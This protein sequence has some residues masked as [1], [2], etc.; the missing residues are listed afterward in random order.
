MATVEAFYHLHVKN[1]G[2]RHGRSVVA[3]A[4]YRAGETLW[5]EAEERESV[6]GGRRDVVHAEI[7]LP[8]GAPHWMAV[9]ATLW[10]AVEA[11]EKRHDARLAKEIEFSLPREL[12]REAWIN[13]AREMADAYTS[14]GFVVDLAVH[15]DGRGHNPHVHLLLATRRVTATGFSGKLRRA[16]S[17]AFITEA[18]QRWQQVANTALGKAGANAQ[19][20]ARSYK[21]RGMD[22]TPTRHHGPDPAARAYGRHLAAVIGGL[23]MLRSGDGAA[24]RDILL[25]GDAHERHALLARRDDWPPVSREEPTDLSPAERDAF[26]AWWAEV[27]QRKSAAPDRAP[28]EDPERNTTAAERAVSAVE[29]LERRLEDLADQIH[30]GL[31]AALRDELDGLRSE[32]LALRSIEEEHTALQARDRER[33][34]LGER[35]LPTPGEDGT[36]VPAASRNAASDDLSWSPDFARRR[37]T[38]SSRSERSQDGPRE[39]RS[40]E[41]RRSPE[42]RER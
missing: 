18:R 30:P 42:D 38:S 40:R 9:R 25:E 8:D 28:S 29:R 5:N 10:N 33:A 16:D 7:R 26:A 41:D 12:R 17:L 27:D 21:A 22:R 2:R 32:L 6:F 19:I 11:S 20:D 24:L 36:L 4:A 35:L 23:L 37:D 14:Q 3:A 31:D 34:Q 39:G 1:I 15:E 13:V